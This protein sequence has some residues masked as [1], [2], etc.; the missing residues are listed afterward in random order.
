MERPR[1]S[2]LPLKSLGTL[3]HVFLMKFHIGREN[4]GRALDIAGQHLAL[5]AHALRRA[6][7]PRTGSRPQIQ[8]FHALFE[9]LEAPVYFL[10]LIDGA[11]RIVFPFGLEEVMI[12]IFFHSIS[13]L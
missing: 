3:K 10:E 4:G 1:F 7:R 13:T 2:E 5:S 11:G 6:E 8:H 9:N 12:T